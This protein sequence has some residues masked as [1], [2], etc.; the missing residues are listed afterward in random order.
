D[1]NIGE[2]F[3]DGPTS[4]VKLKGVAPVV[5]PGNCDDMTAAA[6][7]QDAQCSPPA[8]TCEGQLLIPANPNVDSTGTHAEYNRCTV[9]KAALV[10]DEMYLTGLTATTDLGSITYLG[11][12]Q[13]IATQSGAGI[14]ILKATDLRVA[15]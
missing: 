13:P 11:G 10:T 4:V 5:G 9:A 6:C 2:F 7:T 14:H 8:V 12:A 15:V 3:V 1:T